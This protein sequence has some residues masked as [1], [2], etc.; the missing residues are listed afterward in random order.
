[1]NTFEEILEYVKKCGCSVQY[2]AAPYYIQQVPEEIS[3]LLFKLLKT[4]NYSNFM[5]IGSA[6]GGTSRL[7]NDFFHFKKMVILDNNSRNRKMVK[8]REK[9]LAGLPLVEFV[10]DSQGAEA[11]NFVRNLRIELDLLFIDGDHSYK[12]VKNDYN[13]HLEFVRKGGYLIFHDTVSYP[14]VGRFV[15]EVKLDGN[16]AFVD[17]YRNK[18]QPMCGLALFKKVS[19]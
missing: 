17:E 10:G 13:N 6:A 12:G 15:N 1:M 4:N 7:F 3:A 5:E 2:D 8:V 9:Q 18:N 14:E 19:K 11:N 16:V